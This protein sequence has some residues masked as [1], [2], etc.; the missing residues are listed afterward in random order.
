VVKRV[1]ANTTQLQEWCKQYQFNI[2]PK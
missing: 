1:S 2:L